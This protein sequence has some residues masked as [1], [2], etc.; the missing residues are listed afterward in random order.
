MMKAVFSIALLVII[1]LAIEPGANATPL[2]GVIKSINGQPIAKVKVLTFAPLGNPT[3]VMGVQMGAQRFEVTSDEQGVFRLP[4]HGRV[5]YFTLAQQQRPVT[6]ILSLTATNIQVVMEEAA[7]TLWKIPLCKATADETRSGVAFKV[8]ASDNVLV[9]KIV[10]F[11]LDAYGYGYQLP[12]GKFASMANWQ[13]SSPSHPDETLLLDAKQLAERV[14]VAGER[15]GYDVRG[16][17]AD[18]TFWRFVSYRWGAISYHHILPAAAKSFDKMLDGMC[19]D[20]ADA[21]KY[22]NENF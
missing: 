22:P 10:R 9:K 20:E 5:V 14:W 16:V 17:S 7:P 2:T 19:F 18:G 6:K 21:K 3:K 4:D 11:D 8:V 13:D 1:G 15:F 12:D